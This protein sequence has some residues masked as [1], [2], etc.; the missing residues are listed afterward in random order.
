M[1]NILSAFDGTFIESCSSH[2]SSKF[3]SLFY[4]RLNMCVISSKLK[5]MYRSFCANTV[6]LPHFV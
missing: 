2:N 6:S 1:L 4:G 3:R 5:N